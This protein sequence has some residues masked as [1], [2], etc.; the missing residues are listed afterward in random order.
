MRVRVLFFGVL[1]EIFGTEDKVLDLQKGARV[2]DLTAVLFEGRLGPER[3]WAR[4]MAVAVNREY[5]KAEDTLQ[6]GDE[7]ALLPPVSG[8]GQ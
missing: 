4:S 1:K 5:A 6:D 7:V 8:G 2:A 3:E